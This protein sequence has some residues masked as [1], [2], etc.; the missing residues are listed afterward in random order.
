MNKLPVELWRYIFELNGE[1]PRVEFYY[2]KFYVSGNKFK[3]GPKMLHMRTC[4]RPKE[5]FEELI[6]MLSKIKR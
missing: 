4:G 3:A 5:E 1:K 6:R 2:P